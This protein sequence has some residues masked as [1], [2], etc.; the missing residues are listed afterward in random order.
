[1]ADPLHQF[2]VTPIIPIEI[3]GVDLSFT[4]ASLWMVIGAVVSTLFLTMSMKRKALVPSRAQAMAEMVYEFVANMVRENIGSAGRQYFP[5]IFTL[6]IVVLMGNLL[7]LIPYSFTYTSHLIVTGALAI[8]VFLT[9]LLIGVFR[10]GMHFFSLFVPPGVPLWLFPLIIP[11][12]LI[13]FLIRPVTLSVRLF[14]NM[15]AGHLMLKVFAGFSV[16][17]FAALG[18][19]GILPGLLPMAFNTVLTAFELL[20]ALIHAYVFAVLSC[21]YLKDTV[22]LHH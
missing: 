17:M 8:L 9:V 21:I 14:A 12:E 3:G 11:I 10:H 20:V 16:A 4:N 15:M 22:D 18:A 13:S 19:K 1:M 6:F 5:L 2:V 7:G